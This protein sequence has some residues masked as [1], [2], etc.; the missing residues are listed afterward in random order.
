MKYFEI[1]KYGTNSR[2]LP[3]EWIKSTYEIDGDSNDTGWELPS[4]SH[5]GIIMTADEMNDHVSTYQSDFD[6]WK[7][8]NIPDRFQI[9]SRT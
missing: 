4:P 7:N 5:G 6:S 8:E 1:V 3:V 9:S 2:N